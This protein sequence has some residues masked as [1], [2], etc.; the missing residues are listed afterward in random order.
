[1]SSNSS[2]S[3]YGG[4]T[5]YTGYT[6]YHNSSY[7]TGKLPSPDAPQIKD[8]VV[9]A[10][11]CNSID[12][13]SIFKSQ[14]AQYGSAFTVLGSVAVAEPTPA[15]EVVTGVFGLVVTLISVVELGKIVYKGYVDGK[16]ID[17]DEDALPQIYTEPLPTIH[18]DAIEK[19][20]LPDLDSKDIIESLPLPDENA[21]NITT[22]PLPDEKKDLITDSITSN[23]GNEID[24]NPSENHSSTYK[25]PGYRGEPNSSIDILDKDGNVLTRRWFDENGNATRD[26][27]MT[28][29][30]N[31]KQHPEWP[32]EHFWS[33]DSNGKPIGR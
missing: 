10:T 17:L 7:Q 11:Y 19:F 24:I 16:F 9:N 33:Y 21:G 6:G 32:H 18:K 8:I 5:G 2:V 14:F 12:V 26:V 3:G 15:G 30:G 29:H 28:N 23:Q 13:A 1:M 31:S 20:P 27:D 22:L 4:H 25:N